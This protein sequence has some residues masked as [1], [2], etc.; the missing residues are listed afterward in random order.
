MH[1]MNN[2]QGEP[3]VLSLNELEN[4]LKIITKEIKDINGREQIDILGLDAC[5]MAMLE[6][7]YQVKDYADYLVSSENEEALD[8]WPYDR[9]VESIIEN[10]EM[11]GLHFSS[12]IVDTYLDSI[13]GNP[14]TMSNVLTLSVVDLKLVG[15]IAEEIDILASLLLR[16]KRE[17]PGR[18]AF[19]EKL[20][21]KFHISAHIAGK[22][23]PYSVL[24]DLNDFVTNLRVGM[25]KNKQVSESAQRI[26]RLLSKAIIKE[27]HQPLEGEHD[28]GIGGISLYFAGMDTKGYR[29]NSF[30]IDTKWDEY[31][32]KSYFFGK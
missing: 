28:L 11:D 30:S 26:S 20:T 7:M 9:L 5:Y 4:A 3:D 19:A 2:G 18:L 32:T 31:I 13:K 27:R 25:T 17:S 16:L 10:S 29:G 21:N 12:S 23:V 24:L 6:I 1:D 15:K 22:Y 14:S 8:G